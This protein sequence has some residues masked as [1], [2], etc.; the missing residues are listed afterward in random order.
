MKSNLSISQK[1]LL[2]A[3][4]S[5]VMMI[6]LVSITAYFYFA[7][8]Q[9]TYNLKDVGFEIVNTMEGVRVK[10]KRYLQFFTAELENQLIQRVGKIT[11]LLDYLKE[12]ELKHS[13]SVVVSKIEKEKTIYVSKFKEVT[14]IHQDGMELKRAMTKP[15]L[16]AKLN[17]DGIITILNEKQ[18]NLMIEGEDLTGPDAELM[19]LGRE[20]KIFIL[21]LELLLQKYISTGDKHYMESFNQLNSSQAEN[22]LSS[23]LQLSRLINNKDIIRHSTELKKQF[24]DFQ[25]IAERLQTSSKQERS[26]I[27]RLDEVGVDIVSSTRTLLKEADDELTRVKKIVIVANVLI[28]LFGLA[29]F[30]TIAFGLI[31]SISRTLSKV[32]SGLNESAG[33]VSEASGEVSSSSQTLADGASSQAS[34][35][36][37]TSSS[38]K[39]IA[40]MTKQNAG[41][42]QEADHLMKDSQQL[43]SSANASISD[44]NAAI[45]DVAN[46]SNETY[47]IIKTID[48]IAFQTNLLALNAA[49][50]SARAGEAG[51]GFAVVASEVRNLALRSTEAAKNTSLLIEGTSKKVEYGAN[52]VAQTTDA[53]NLV[54]ENA[55]KVA[56]IVSEISEASHEQANSIDQLNIAVAEMGNITEKNSMKSEESASTAIQLYNQVEQMKSFVQDLIN[57]A[58]SSRNNSQ[59]KKA[60]GKLLPVPPHTRENNHAKACV[61]LPDNSETPYFG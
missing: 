56:A 32:I 31:R 36:E 33:L 24:V 41:N 22:I 38:L 30:A 37:E 46:A 16:N 59:G 60:S 42:A 35:L 50:E 53:F 21:N 51:E 13:W 7:K 57:F 40:S 15:V 19:T 34:S 9:P 3:G 20:C 44:L 52:L 29:L 4:L 39:S 5:I 10:E 27:K 1:L 14:A 54:V 45:T 8:V 58:G 49:V 18:A 28:I 23:A 61:H 55:N 47:K 25:S 48:E 43:V 17:I 2:F 6:T 11:Q 26:E 12:T